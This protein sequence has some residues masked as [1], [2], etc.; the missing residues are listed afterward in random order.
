[1]GLLIME[2]INSKSK[3]Y[4]AWQVLSRAV[5]NNQRISL[6]FPKVEAQCEQ[7]LNGQGKTL[8]IQRNHAKQNHQSAEL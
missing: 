6:A 8:Y 5:S 7:I 1:M 2:K 3:K 4:L